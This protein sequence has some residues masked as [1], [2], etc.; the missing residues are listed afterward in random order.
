M[1]QSLVSQDESAGDG[2][3]ILLLEGA[4]CEIQSR[5]RGKQLEAMRVPQQK[6]KGTQMRAQLHLLCSYIISLLH[7]DSYRQ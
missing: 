5:W 3:G 1:T 4:R 2:D 6:E 7:Y